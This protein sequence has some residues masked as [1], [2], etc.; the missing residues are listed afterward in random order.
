MPTTRNIKILEPYMGMVESI[1]AEPEVP[2]ILGSIL[3]EYV[4]LTEEEPALK[5]RKITS[6]FEE[7]NE[8][9]RHTRFICINCVIIIPLKKS[10][11]LYLPQASSHENISWSLLAF[12]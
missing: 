10:V 2:V 9:P 11:L 7:S 3:S 12:T 4:V 5:K 8:I 6:N 1:D